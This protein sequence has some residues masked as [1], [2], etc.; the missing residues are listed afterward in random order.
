MTEYIADI[1]TKNM[2]T[3]GLIEEHEKSI[4]YYSIQV[5]IERI[6]GFSAIFLIAI[7]QRILLETVLFTL[8]FFNLRK[9]TGGFH[10]KTF[11]RCFIG[12]ISIYSI[13][14]KLIYPILLNKIDI[15]MVIL[16]GAGIVVFMLGA[17]NHPNMEWN[18]KEHEENK[19]LARVTVLL[20]MLIIIIFAYLGMA[21][22]YILFMSFGIILCAVLLLLGKIIG[23]EVKCYE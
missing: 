1:L 16:G 12:T 4:Y 19:M 10:T 17:V 7:L 23:Q 14:V 20:E 21:E 6:I 9:Y 2:I 11:I 15:N 13:Y 3:D 22:K 18:K 5:L 8:C